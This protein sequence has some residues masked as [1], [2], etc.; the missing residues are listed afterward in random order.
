MARSAY[1]GD[2][3][4]AYVEAYGMPGPRVVPSARWSDGTARCQRPRTPCAPPA[5]EASKGLILRFAPDSLRWGNSHLVARRRPERG[6][7]RRSSRSPRLG[8]VT[9]FDD[10]LS[11]LRYFP[12][13][14]G[15]RLPPQ[16]APPEERT[17]CVEQLLA[18]TDPNPAT[19]T[20][21]ALDQYFRRVALANRRFPM[22][23]ARVAHRSGRG[24]HPAG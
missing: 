18:E 20:N 11:L 7:L 5:D 14:A 17:E 13:S 4:L 10:M 8:L 21:E 19:P 3:A 1:G 15:A 24:V 2:T 23:G 16:G 22:K 12:P 9:N 6:R